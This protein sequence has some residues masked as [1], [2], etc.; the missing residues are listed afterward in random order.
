MS[1]L[2]FSKIELN[3]HKFYEKEKIMVEFIIG[4][5]IKTKQDKV[6]IA[7]KAVEITDKLTDS[8]KHLAGAIK[9]QTPKDKLKVY[10]LGEYKIFAAV[11]DKKFSKFKWQTFGAE[12][13]KKIKNCQNLKA[14]IYGFEDSAYFDFAFGL[15]LAAYRFDKYFTKKDADFFPKLEQIEFVGIKDFSDYKDYAAVSNCVRYARDLINEPANNM[16]PEIL[17]EDIRR[18]EYLGLNVEI[19]DEKQ[20]KEQ[21]FNLALAV[22]QGSTN[23][24]RIGVIKWIGDKKSNDFKIGLVGKGVTFD[25]GGISLKSAANMG[26]MK[27]D[28]AGSAV[29]VSV[30]KALA[31][32]KAPK[33]VVAVVGLVE[34]MPSGSA[35]RPGDIVRSMS[36]QTVEIGNTDAEGRL[37]FADCLTYIQKSFSPQYVIDMATLTGAIV[38]ALGNT[39]AGLFS[40]NDKFADIIKSSGEIC[41]ER[42]WRMPMDA[43]FDKMMD[44]SVADMTN[45]GGR[46]AGS[47]TAACFLQRFVEKNTKWAHIDIAGMDLS[48]GSKDMY[49][50]VASGYGVLL[51]N[52]VLKKL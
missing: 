24:P 17:A 14:A 26:D 30:M 25:S 36:G 33:N 31:L 44:S 42:V 39:F 20:M 9:K 34:N 46:N 18:L 48:K 1:I 7:G 40:N 11:V 23:P 16:T 28:M 29:M 21:G 4:K 37:V 45:I 41:G 8:E 2:F 38:V 6:L 52:E 3:L 22:G 27:Q 50:K 5:N 49:P 19:L 43:E 13:Y 15:E 51:L 10:D 47:A 32:Q 35:T 12:C